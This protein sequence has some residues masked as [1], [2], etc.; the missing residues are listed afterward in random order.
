VD[1]SLQ[2]FILAVVA[3]IKKEWL[4]MIL[5]VAFLIFCL[6]SL[7][8]IYHWYRY[9]RGEKGVLIAGA[10]YFIGS[11]FLFL[12]AVLSIALYSNV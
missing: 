3:N 7:V 2:E 12:G 11:V 4:W 6:I 9:G 1:F 8:L 5:L 10:V